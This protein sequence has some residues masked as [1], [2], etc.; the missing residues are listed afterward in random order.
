[1]FHTNRFLVALGAKKSEEVGTE[2]PPASGLR[3]VESLGEE[4]P[5]EGTELEHPTLGRA[6][7]DKFKRANLG[8]MMYDR[9]TEVELTPE[10]WAAFGVKELKLD[11][12]VK[13]GH[14][15][16]YY[17]PAAATTGAQKR[18]AKAM[19]QKAKGVKMIQRAKLS[20]EE[21]ERLKRSTLVP[22]SHGYI[23]FRWTCG[24]IFN[25]SVFV[26]SWLVCWIYGVTFGPVAFG[27]ILLAWGL[28]LFQ[29]FVIVEPAEVIGIVVFPSIAENK[30]VA[31]C[32]HFLKEY[33]FI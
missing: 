27:S 17:Q 30:Y 28:A 29:T 18:D 1:V 16:A 8:R 26:G 9:L 14:G 19:W 24:W 32:R 10:E 4:Q 31:K 5:E 22:F 3:W 15:D 20:V 6:L 13:S 23:L 25:L 21:A 12:Y 33:G 11:H 7:A 2:P